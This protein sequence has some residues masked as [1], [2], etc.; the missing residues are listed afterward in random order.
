VTIRTGGFQAQSHEELKDIDQ[1]TLVLTTK[2]LAFAG[3]KRSLVTDL[4]KLVSVD[5][6]GD[7]FAVR[8][9]GKEKTEFYLGLDRHSSEFTVEGLLKLPN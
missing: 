1:G 3:S 5:A 8:Q 9:A 2:R 6:Y 7:G 4:P